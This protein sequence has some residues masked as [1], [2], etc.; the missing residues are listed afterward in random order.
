MALNVAL[1]DK[2]EITKKMISHCLHYYAAQVQRFEN[3]E[4]MQSRF[5]RTKPDI[6]FIDWDL[7]KDE[8]PLA[9]SLGGED[10]STP[11]IV[12]HRDTPSEDLNKMHNRIKKPI[13][14]NRLREMVVKLVP[15]TNELKIHKFLKYPTKESYFAGN[16]GDSAVDNGEEAF[17][18]PDAESGD[19]MNFSAKPAEVRAKSTANQ[20]DPPSQLKGDSAVDKGEETFDLPDAESGDPMDFSAKPAEVRAKST[21]NQVDP[22]PA[23]PKGKNPALSVKQDNTA[24][25][26]PDIEDDQQ[27]YRIEKTGQ[28][29][30]PESEEKAALSGELKTDTATEKRA[31]KEMRPQPPTPEEPQPESREDEAPRFLDKEGIDLDENTAN[32]FAP[33]A[34]SNRA[35][36]MDGTQNRELLLKVLEDYKDTLEFENI[37]EKVLKEYGEKMVRRIVERD[38]QDTIHKAFTAYRDT[39]KFQTDLKGFFKDWLEN[40]PDMRK[41]IESAFAGFMEKSLPLLAREII[42]REI[43]KLLKE[44]A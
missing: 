31:E 20:V 4:D 24:F 43:Q 15:K 8:K 25:N 21:A 29:A 19:P 39:P 28:T 38:G 32:D 30:L 42:E 9:L 44:D 16:G 40:S 27:E 11:F 18:L 7:K 22:S 3:L 17:D 6:V 33:A 2:S 34:L 41:H 26:L 1:I 35:V 14:A 36:D 5:H 23:Q 12:L 13:D 10:P 37:I